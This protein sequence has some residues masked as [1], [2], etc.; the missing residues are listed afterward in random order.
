L[1]KR[2]SAYLTMKKA[3][4]LLLALVAGGWSPVVGKSGA[5]GNT[6]TRLA[7]QK[8][9]AGLTG[10]G[11]GQ[12]I[13]ATAGQFA[14]SKAGVAPAGLPVSTQANTAGPP[15]PTSAPK[16]DTPGTLI[17]DESAYCRSYYQYACDVIDAKLLKEQGEKILSKYSMYTVAVLEPGKNVLLIKS[18][19][20]GWKGSFV[21]TYRGEGL[22]VHLPEG[23]K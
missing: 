10:V 2:M 9:R 16:G 21:V 11:N 1:I 7:V 13:E 14:E 6:S 20:K 22:T 3:V 19:S 12:R 8:G 23:V 17:L 5:V 4:I 15:G 18:T